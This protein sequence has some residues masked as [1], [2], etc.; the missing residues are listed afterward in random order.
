MPKLIHYYLLISNTDRRLF[1]NKYVLFNS[2]ANRYSEKYC[3]MT[4][5][6]WHQIIPS[7]FISIFSY[8]FRNFFW[9][10]H[11]S[12]ALYSLL[13]FLKIIFRIFYYFC[14]HINVQFWPSFLSGFIDSMHF[15]TFQNYFMILCLFKM[16]YVYNTFLFII[17]LA[18]D[19]PTFPISTL[20]G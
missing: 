3:C 18:T 14:F 19:L 17:K 15:C 10:L 7:C 8:I 6:F 12:S 9:K 13:I 4:V 20:S 16:S 11:Y 2:N 5:W 1:I